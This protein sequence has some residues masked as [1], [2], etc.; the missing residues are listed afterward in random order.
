MQIWTEKNIDSPVLRIDLD[1][2]FDYAPPHQLIP[3][4]QQNEKK[5]KDEDED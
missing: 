1:I 2:L 3:K 4:K 5:F